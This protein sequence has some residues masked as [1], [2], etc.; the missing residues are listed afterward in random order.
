MSI[1]YLI[2]DYRNY[3]KMFGSSAGFFPTLLRLGAG[4]FPTSFRQ[5]S[6]N[7]HSA[8]ASAEVPVLS[9]LALHSFVPLCV[10]GPV[11]SLPL[12]S[13]CEDSLLSRTFPSAGTV[14]TNNPLHSPI[15]R[16]VS[17]PANDNRPRRGRGT[18]SG[19]AARTYTAPG[20]SNHTQRGTRATLPPGT[21]AEWTGQ[22]ALNGPGW[23]DRLGGMSWTAR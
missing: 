12:L 9:G 2:F 21:W 8:T 3:I 16:A 15:Q 11:S 5:T 7:V 18:T 19:A 4:F 13:V 17:G 10:C 14:N 22:A 20:R 6:W 23:K 1:K